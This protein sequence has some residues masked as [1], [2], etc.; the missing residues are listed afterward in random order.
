[1]SDQDT[2]LLLQTFQGWLTEKQER[3]ARYLA[4]RERRR[5]RSHG[6]LLPTETDEDYSRDK[7]FEARLLAFLQY[8]ERQLNPQDD[9]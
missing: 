4:K 3:E 1:M 6:A 5:Q 7:P 9:G 2:R 8:L